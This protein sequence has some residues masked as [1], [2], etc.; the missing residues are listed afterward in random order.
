[1]KRILGLVVVLL[2]TVGCGQLQLPK[3]IIVTPLSEQDVLDA[4]ALALIGANADLGATIEEDDKPQACP[5][6][7]TGRSG[8]GLGP[9]E[10]AGGCK[11][12]A[13]SAAPI[14]D[15][16][17]EPSPVDEL[18]PEVAEDPEPVSSDA[19]V[20]SVSAEAEL[21]QQLADTLKQ[22]SE[23]DKSTATVVSALDKRITALEASRQ[24]ATTAT[25]TKAVNDSPERQLIILY[26]DKDID[27]IDTWETEQGSQLVDV[28]W[29]V[30]TDS[31]YQV[32]KLRIEAPDAGQYQQAL[33]LATKNGTPYWAVFTAAKFQK[34]GVG[35][36]AASVVSTMLNTKLAPATSQL[37]P[38]KTI[39]ETWPASVP[40]NGTTTPSK[41]AFVSHLRGGGKG[42]EDHVTKYFQSWP[43]ESMTIGQ[44]A[45]LHDQDHS[46]STVTS[47]QGTT[48]Q[49]TVKYTQPTVQY[50]QPTQSNRR[51]GGFFQSRGNCAN[52][53]CF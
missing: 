10:C 39:P 27:A 6:G 41:R 4:R 53:K 1:M 21:L 37:E 38:W 22:L 16:D 35:L 20:G 33:E 28:G 49:P 12:K 17:P 32:V 45:T 26:T 29:S 46:A 52:G 9:C 40:I 47:N 24:T 19:A 25:V 14:S 48:T 34:G 5:C 2:L 18:E 11:C 15:P 7:G 3:V 31:S 13:R 36:P 42:G 51:R 30:G 8:D 23:I 43:L 50:M 44:L